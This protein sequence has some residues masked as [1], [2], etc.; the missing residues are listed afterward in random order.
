MMRFA[1]LICLIM[2]VSSFAAESKSQ[3]HELGFTKEEHMAA[4]AACKAMNLDIRG[5]ELKECIKEKLNI[6]AQ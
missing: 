5:K 1:V 4:E 3:K 6:K 2:S